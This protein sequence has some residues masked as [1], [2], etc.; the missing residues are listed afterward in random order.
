MTTTYTTDG[1]RAIRKSADQFGEVQNVRDAATVFADRLARRE[2][3][4]SGYARIVRAD[5]CTPDGSSHTF[6][7]FIGTDGPQHGTTVG[8]NEWL[9]VDVAR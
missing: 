6:Q 7:V 5:S 4:R 8:R 1:F 3:G 9:Y 2:Y